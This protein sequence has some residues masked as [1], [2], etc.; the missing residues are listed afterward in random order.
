MSH[1]DVLHGSSYGFQSCH[2]NG[3]SPVAVSRASPHH[4]YVAVQRTDSG[5]DSSGMACLKAGHTISEMKL[6]SCCQ[7]AFALLYEH[8]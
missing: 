2:S 8:Y 7:K 4:R 1:R 6:R 3:I 5:A